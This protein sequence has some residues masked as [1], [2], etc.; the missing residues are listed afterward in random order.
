MTLEVIAKPG[1]STQAWEEQF[2]LDSL[3]YFKGNYT[4][5]NEFIQAKVVLNG[6]ADL[7]FSVRYS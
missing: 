7:L 2:T 4:C 1:V 3:D 5:Q 6:A